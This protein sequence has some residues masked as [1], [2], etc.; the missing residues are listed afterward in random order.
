LL[1]FAIMNSYNYRVCGLYVETA[2]WGEMRTVP[3]MKYVLAVGQNL[4]MRITQ[5]SLQGHLEA[6]GLLKVLSG[7][8]QKTNLAVGI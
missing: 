6:V 8:L 1:S 3:P 2:P 7:F 5:L 4:A